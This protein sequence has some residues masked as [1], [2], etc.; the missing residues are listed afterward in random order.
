MEN[1]KKKGKLITLL[2]NHIVNLESPFEK[3]PKRGEYIV[4]KYH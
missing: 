2:V 4:I 1:I 3:A